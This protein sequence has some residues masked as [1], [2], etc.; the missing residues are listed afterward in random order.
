MSA[1]TII[2]PFTITTSQVVKSFTVSCRG[3]NLFN[4]A[5]FAV[6]SFDE[7]GNLV[8]RKIITITNEEYTQWNNDDSFIVDLMAQKLGYTLEPAVTVVPEEPSF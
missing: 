5:T 6:D 3:I 7:I 8:S 1:P 4:N 2:E